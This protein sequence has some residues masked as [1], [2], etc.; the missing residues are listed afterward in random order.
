MIG[1]IALNRE[2]TRKE[3]YSSTLTC[4]L[5]PLGWMLAD[6]FLPP[7]LGQPGQ[8]RGSRQT[9]PHT[10]QARGRNISAPPAGKTDFVPTRVNGRANNFRQ[11]EFPASPIL[12]TRVGPTQPSL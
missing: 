4:F 6:G 11:T 8:P 12:R 1:T 10:R 2:I 9:W 7:E 5:G 3:V